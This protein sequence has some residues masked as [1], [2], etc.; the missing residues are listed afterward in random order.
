[1]VERDVLI[2]C[3]CFVYCIPK[4]F[5]A[6]LDAHGFLASGGMENVVN[7]RDQLQGFRFECV[8]RGAETVAAT[9]SQ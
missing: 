3:V 9:L 8:S 6:G 2:V 7:M 1:M 4:G 5:V